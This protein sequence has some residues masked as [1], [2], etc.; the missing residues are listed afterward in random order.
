[1]NV[2]GSVDELI[3]RALVTAKDLAGLAS[4]ARAVITAGRRTGTTG[5]TNLI[6]VREIP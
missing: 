6:M 5:A 3:D 2:S 1:M 4:G